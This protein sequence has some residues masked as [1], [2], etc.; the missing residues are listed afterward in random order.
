MNSIYLDNSA[1]TKVCPEAAEASLKIMTEVYGNPSSTHTMGR[2]AAAALKKARSQV[3]KAL[4]SLPEEVVFTSCGSESDNWAVIRGAESRA[5]SGKHIISSEVEHDAVRKS[6]D[7]LESNGFEI[8]RLSPEKDGSVSAESVLNAVRPDTILISLMM[9]NNE[10]GG[11]TDIGNIARTVKAQNN[12]ILIHTDAVQSFMKIPFAAKKLNVDFI[13]ISGHKI[14]APKGIGALYIR[15]NTKIPPYILGGN[16][17]YGL[18]AGTEALPQIVA[19]GTA[20]EI[21][22][23]NFD[24]NVEHMKMLKTELVRELNVRIPFAKII[25]SGAPHIVNVSLPGY[26][27]EVLMNFLESKHIY[28]SRSSA[29]KRGARSHVL[30][31]MG[32]DPQIIDG[33]IRVSFSRYNN[34][35]EVNTFCDVLCEGVQSLSHR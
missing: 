3:A 34:I 28:V 20:T 2:E 4:G 32:L 14:H 10:T 11:V 5:R 25:E 22:Y 35:S 33:A 21:A 31:A 18:R 8:T 13:S 15:K 19:L 16:Q 6:L 29:C 12:S 24:A 1:T 30:E 7:Y 9:V 23:N 26:R 17:E 27:S